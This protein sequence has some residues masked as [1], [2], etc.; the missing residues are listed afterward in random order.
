MQT[1]FTV[2]KVFVVG[3]IGC[4]SACAH[5]PCGGHT[6]AITASGEGKASGAPDQA[7][8]TV[9]A[10]TEAKDAE[11]AAAQSATVQDRIIS[12]AK[13]LVGTQGS[14]KTSSY[15]LNPVY[16]FHENKQTLRGYQVRNAITIELWN[17]KGVG[18]LID[19][20][21]K[22]GASEVS[23]IVFGVRESGALRTQAIANASKAALSEATAA[24]TALGLRVGKVRT[25]AVGSASGGVPVPMNK[26]SR[27]MDSAQ[28]ATPVEAGSVDVTAS[29]SIETQ[30]EKP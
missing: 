14:V 2:A 24:A 3:A 22:A 4:L 1:I 8:I 20:T 6:S 13:A 5:G 18:A 16:D 28:V 10:I 27:S 25:I 12:A 19:A 26:F 9:A 15:S 30:L 11:G 7:S 21:V 23:S 17:T 29:V